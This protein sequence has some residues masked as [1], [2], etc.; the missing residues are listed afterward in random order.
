MQGKNAMKETK[1][2][3]NSND[4]NTISLPPNNLLTTQVL[5][6]L[7]TV[8]LT[9]RRIKG[10]IPLIETWNTENLINKSRIKQDGLAIMGDFN[11]SRSRR[12][13][14][15]RDLQERGRLIPQKI[16]YSNIRYSREFLQC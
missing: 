10:I 2:R 1:G 7:K 15:T 13:I 4:R 5:R 16:K 3:I 6:N 12:W 14:H 8:G 11:G 9:E